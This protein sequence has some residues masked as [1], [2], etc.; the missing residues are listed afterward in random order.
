MSNTDNVTQWRQRLR[1]RIAARARDVELNPPPD[2]DV[3]YLPR[4]VLEEML[5]CVLVRVRWHEARRYKVPGPTLLAL[6]HLCRRLG[7]NPTEI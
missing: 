3:G 2:T 5:E 6:N 1:E 7:K 4:A